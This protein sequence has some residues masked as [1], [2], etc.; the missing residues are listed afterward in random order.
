MAQIRQERR[1][2]FLFPITLISIGAIWLLFEAR[3][4][5]G[6]NLYMLLRFWPIILIGLGLELLVGRNQRSWSLMIALGTV[7]LLLALMLV[8]PALGLA[9]SVEVKENQYSTPL[10]GMTSAGI[11]LDLSSGQATV[12]ALT[13]AN[14]LITAD[15]R[16]VGSINYSAGGSNG[17]GTVRLSANDDQTQIVSFLGWS[18]VNGVDANEL[19]WNIGL[20]PNIPLDLTINGG[21]GDNTIDLSGL[22]ITSLALNGGVGQDRITLPASG[23]FNF[24]MNGGIGETWVTIPQGVTGD[25]TINA[26]VG[27]LHLD[28]PENTPVRLEATGGLGLVQVP[29][30]MQ[31]VSGG[32]GV[33]QRTWETS[34]YQAAAADARLTIHF[35]GGVGE[36]SVQ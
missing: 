12:K 22:Q 35:T 5:S 17:R 34:S 26:G 33:E 19:R 11:N 6:A 8:G 28:L 27:Q 9:P 14:D 10:A 16:Y 2:S 18:L 3:I 32:S 24:T 25:T 7:V 13:D 23:H 29:D 15:L 1:H 30:W 20:S 21:V 4:F 31:H 36:L